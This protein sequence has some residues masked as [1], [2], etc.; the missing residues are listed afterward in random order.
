[1][2]AFVLIL[3]LMSVTILD[4]VSRRLATV[5]RRYRGLLAGEVNRGPF[6]SAAEGNTQLTIVNATPLLIRGRMSPLADFVNI[7]LSTYYNFHHFIKKVVGIKGVI[8]AT[9]TFRQSRLNQTTLFNYIV[10]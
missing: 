5:C 10:N 1:M 3:A 4:A 2:P 7:P 6:A 8:H 9:M